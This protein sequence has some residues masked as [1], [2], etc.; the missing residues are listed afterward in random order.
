MCQCFILKK[1]GCFALRHKGFHS[2]SDISKQKR[3]LGK[4]PLNSLYWLNRL[5]RVDEVQL[6]SPEIRTNSKRIRHFWSEENKSP[7]IMYYVST[8]PGWQPPS[9]RSP[10]SCTSGR[11][12]RRRSSLQS[13]PRTGDLATSLDLHTHNE[14][15]NVNLI[16]MFVG[17]KGKYTKSS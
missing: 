13:R 5:V 10:Q 9:D 15:F 16:S 17:L 2:D 4:G 7:C 14:E 11:S 6:N 3:D 8:L 1:C 12:T